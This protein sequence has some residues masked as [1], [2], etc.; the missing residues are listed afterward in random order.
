MIP[1]DQLFSPRIEPGTFCV[2][3]RRDN[4]YTTKTYHI[5]VW[6]YEKIYINCFNILALWLVT[7]SKCLILIGWNYMC[8]PIWGTNRECTPS[9]PFGVHLGY[10]TK[11]PTFYIFWNVKFYEKNAATADIQQHRPIVN[12]DIIEKNNLNRKM[13]K[14]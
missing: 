10:K 4:H 7:W 8:T 5:Y 2:L 6:K 9:T 14:S 3:D 13:W 12:L 1:L 11:P